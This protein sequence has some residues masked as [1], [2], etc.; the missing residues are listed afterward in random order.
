M[1][2]EKGWGG[3]PGP[4]GHFL[5]CGWLEGG[6]CGIDTAKLVV[7]S[8]GR[9]GSSHF[10][11]LIFFMMYIRISTESKV[12]SLRLGELEVVRMESWKLHT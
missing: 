5:R 6:V 12:S 9:Q 7:L 8:L 1:V 4:E 10:M 3:W 11:S 2:C